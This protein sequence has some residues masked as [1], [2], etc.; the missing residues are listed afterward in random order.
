MNHR[1]SGAKA[2]PLDMELNAFANHG[3][4]QAMRELGKSLCTGLTK[5]GPLVARPTNI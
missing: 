3:V 5:R 4:A 1:F 2:L